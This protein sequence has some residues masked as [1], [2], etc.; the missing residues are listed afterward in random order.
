MLAIAKEL[1]TVHKVR[2][3]KTPGAYNDG[4]GLRLIVTAK[5]TKRWELWISINRRKRELGLGV[6]PDVSLQDARDE[7][8]RIWRGPAMALISDSGG[9]KSRR[10]PTSFS[11]RSRR[12]SARKA[13]SS[14]T[15][16]I[17]S[18]GRARW[19]LRLP[20]L[21]RR[22]RCRYHTAQALSVLTPTWCDKAETAKRVLQRIEMVFKSA[23]VR[24]SREKASPRVGVAEEL[25]TRHRDV[26]HHAALPWR[27][28]PAFVTILQEPNS[29]GCPTPRPAFEF[30]MLTATR[31]SE[32]RTPVGRSAEE[33]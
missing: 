29:K 13:S 4:R 31:S 16:S 23:I 21:R 22:S 1:L 2:S 5:G 30:L 10:G 7:A 32:T 19:K 17:S 18:N 6:F 25:G 24:G 12:I 26:E 20:D 28:V 8:D 11:R 9:A 14:P 15:G 33:I 27:D 3:I